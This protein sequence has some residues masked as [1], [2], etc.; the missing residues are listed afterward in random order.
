MPDLCAICGT[1]D[2]DLRECKLCGQHVCR[3]CGDGDHRRGE[4]ACVYCQEEGGD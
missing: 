1:E 3:E 4:F 2:N